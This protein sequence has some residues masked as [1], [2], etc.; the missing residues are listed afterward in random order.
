MESTSRHEDPFIEI[1]DFFYIARREDN[2]LHSSTGYSKASLEF[3]GLDQPLAEAQT[4]LLKKKFRKQ[5]SEHE[6]SVQRSQMILNL[7]D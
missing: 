7:Y 1:Y 2:P 6:T 3:M 5:K 4:P